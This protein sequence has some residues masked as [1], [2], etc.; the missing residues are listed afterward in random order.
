MPDLLDL[1]LYV[2]MGDFLDELTAQGEIGGGEAAF[3]WC[4][5]HGLDRDDLDYFMLGNARLTGHPKGEDWEA[6]PRRVD[7]DRL[8]WTFHRV[9][10]DRC[11]WEPTNRT[12]VERY[13]RPIGPPKSS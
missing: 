2:E 10:I 9:W 6:R 3:A 8:V 1:N 11:G 7:L 12:A 13:N 5:H 4:R